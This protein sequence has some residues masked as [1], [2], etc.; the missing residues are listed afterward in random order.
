MENEQKAAEK[1]LA[2]FEKKH[3]NDCSYQS[4]GANSPKVDACRE[5]VGYSQENIKFLFLVAVCGEFIDGK[6]VFSAKLSCRRADVK[7]EFEPPVIGEGCGS[8]SQAMTKIESK[9]LTF[10]RAFN[11]SSRLMLYFLSSDNWCDVDEEIS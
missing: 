5:F 11:I 3:F 1:M 10:C 8:L 4:D 2:I 9:A 7:E 6:Q